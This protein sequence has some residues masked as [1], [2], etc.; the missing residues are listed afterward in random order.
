MPCGP[1]SASGV[2]TLAGCVSAFFS[3]E[4][5]D[6]RNRVATYALRVVNA[7][8]SALICRT[9]VISKAGDA[10]LAHPILVEVAPLTTSVAEVPVWASDFPS[11]DRA[12][13]EI[14][15]EGVH[16]IV[17]APAPRRLKPRRTLALA[18]YASLIAALFVLAGSAAVRA[19]LPAIAAFALPPEAVAGTTV[20]AEYQT[21]GWGGLIYSVTAPDGSEIQGGP[22]AAHSGAIPIALPPSDEGAA[23]TVQMTVHGP[24][25]TATA[26]RVLNAIVPKGTRAAQI[27]D[28]WVK[29]TVAQPGETVVVGYAATGEGGYVRLLGTDGTIWAQQPFDHTGATRFVVPPVS[30]LTEMR[31]LLHVTRGRSAVQSMAGLAVVAQPA[32]AAAQAAN[33]LDQTQAVTGG[34]NDTFEVLNRIVK[35]GGTIQV[36]IISPRNGLHIALTDGQSHELTGVDVTADATSVTLRAPVVYAPASYTVVATFT[37]GF[38]QESVVEPVSVLP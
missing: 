13:A 35:S 38:G 16:C 21:G 5:Y 33:D 15:G 8:N 17:E 29:P 6:R 3:L 19:A 12:I 37:D 26:T 10:V 18:G 36:R 25:G 20:R 1:G 34:G 27:D 11:F 24:L 14:N 28:I 30:D 2:Q 31:V 22:L 23:Y 32:P 9:W 7:T 4:G